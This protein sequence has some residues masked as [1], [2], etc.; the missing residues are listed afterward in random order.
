MYVHILWLMCTLLRVCIM[1]LNC[2]WLGSLVKSSS[3]WYFLYAINSSQ[4][5]GYQENGRWILYVCCSMLNRVTMTTMHKIGW[6]TI[7]SN[8]DISNL[9][10]QQEVT[11]LLV[12]IINYVNMNTIFY[13]SY[14]L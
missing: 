7:G 11:N 1:D 9:R 2:S 5:H 8:K 4:D 10:I 6:D 3:C 14:C 13:R 12:H